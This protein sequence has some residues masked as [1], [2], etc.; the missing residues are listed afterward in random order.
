MDK[1]FQ[2]P[3]CVHLD[4]TLCL[5]VKLKAARSSPPSCKTSRPRQMQFCRQSLQISQIYTRPIPTTEFFSVC[6]VLDAS[7]CLEIETRIKYS[8]Q[9]TAS[10]NLCKGTQLLNIMNFKWSAHMSA[11]NNEIK[12]IICSN[13]VTV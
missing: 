11:V 5:E 7:P 8:L 1:C 3:C 4:S 6:S 2:N 9:F 10:R 12:G 13:A